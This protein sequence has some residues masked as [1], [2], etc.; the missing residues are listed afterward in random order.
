MDFDVG[1]G[2]AMLAGLA[3]F[4]TPCILP[5]VPFYLCYISGVT[6][7]Q[8]T[9][10]EQA[11][12]RRGRIILAATMF[13]LGMI[14]VFVGLGAV[15]T[16]FGQ[17]VRAYSVELRWAAAAII[18]VLGLHYLGILRIGFL[19][20]EARLDTGYA[21]LGLF[22]PLLVGMAF[23]FGWTPCVG[24]ILA[25][26]LFKAADAAS[27]AQGALLLLA[28]GIGMTAPFVLAAAFIGP[29]LDWAKGIRHHLPVIEKGIGS[30]LV[31]FAVLIGTNSVNE[32]AA[33]MLEIAPDL[34]LL[35][36][37]ETS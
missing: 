30:M 13:S 27:V 10:R 15:A 37:G 21:P 14:V 2:A 31:L 20:R 9:G 16:A 23:A 22:G 29:F 8:L 19:M 3:S 25:L 28:Y 24:P 32:I 6:F 17:Q 7:E 26:I 11:V 36:V 1:Y 35:Q 4:L 34:G 18:L 12:A 33:W 5:I